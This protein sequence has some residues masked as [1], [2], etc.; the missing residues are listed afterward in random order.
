MASGPVVSGTATYK[1][2]LLANR[3]RKYVAVEMEAAGVMAAAADRKTATLVI[4]GISDPA[5]EGKLLDDKAGIEGALRNVAIKNASEFLFLLMD[6]H[7][8]VYGRPDSAGDQLGEAVPAEGAKPSLVPAEHEIAFS[9]LPDFVQLHGWRIGVDRPETPLPTIRPL[10]DPDL[11]TVLSL[12]G[13]SAARLDYDVPDFARAYDA[14]DIVYADIGAMT[15]YVRLFVMRDGG[16]S[17]CVACNLAK[18]VGIHSRAVAR[19]KWST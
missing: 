4:R 13:P 16:K 17:A 15:F 12:M 6:L 19:W 8:L 9:Y 2:S 3:D 10:S 1:K 14:I 5:D 11:G 7:L 18:H